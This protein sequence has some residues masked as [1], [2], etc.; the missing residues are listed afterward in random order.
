MITIEKYFNLTGM[1]LEPSESKNEVNE[2]IITWK[3]FKE[4]KGSLR[5]LSNESKNQIRIL[6]G[7][8]VQIVTHKF[9]C[10]YFEE[11]IPDKSKIIISGKEYKIKNIQNVMTMNRILQLDLELIK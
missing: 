7:K 6:S 11:E 3:E 2:S 4:V 5:P 1:I 10:S 8:E 9:Y